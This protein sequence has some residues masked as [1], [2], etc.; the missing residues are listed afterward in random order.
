ME[1]QNQQKLAPYRAAG[2]VTFSV[3]SDMI[4]KVLSAQEDEPWLKEVTA[5]PLTGTKVWQQPV[6]ANIRNEMV[7]MMVWIIFRIPAHVPFVKKDL[8]LYNAKQV[9]DDIFGMSKSRYEYDYRIAR[10]VIKI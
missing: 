7:R 9:E 3:Y 10:K 8:L 1:D 2:Q 4:L 5:F 6:T